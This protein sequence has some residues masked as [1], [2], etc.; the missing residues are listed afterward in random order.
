VQGIAQDQP[1]HIENVT[2]FF[3]ERGLII[4]DLYST[5][6]TAQST[7]TEML[8]L[9]LTIQVPADDSIAELREEFMIFCDELNLDAI[10]EAER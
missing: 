10:L 9:N 2:A 5:S 6:Y 1:T 8:T 3:A 4:L 7:G